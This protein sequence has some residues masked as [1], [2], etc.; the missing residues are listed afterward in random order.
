VLDLARLLQLRIKPLSP[1]IVA[2]AAIAVLPVATAAAILPMR[3]QQ[4]PAALGQ[5]DDAMTVA[6]DRNRTNEPLLAEMSKV[7]LAWVAGPAVVILQVA[8]WNDAEHADETQ[9]AG[10]RTAKGVL[11]VSVADELAF[12]SARQVELVYEDVAR[13]DVSRVDRIAVACVIIP[14]ARIAS[15]TWIIVKHGRNLLK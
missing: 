15:P 14:P 13:I 6:G 4:I 12:E 5:D 2:A 9:R 11:A 7:A 10:F 8:R 3:F 1:V